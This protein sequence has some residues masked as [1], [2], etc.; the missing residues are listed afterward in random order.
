MKELRV[1][2]IRNRFFA[3]SGLFMFFQFSGTNSVNYYSP[4]IFA[5]LGITG[6]SVSFLATGIYGVVR[7]CAI[8]IAMIWAVD[9]FGRKIL[10]ITFAAVMAASMWIIGA[11]VK[12]QTGGVA[13]PLTLIY[14]YAA[15]FCF[16][17][18]GIPNMQVKVFEFLL[19]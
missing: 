5:R 7:F 1:P 18:A 11:L 10:L 6:Q 16:S 12:T 13:A 3:I 9:R 17:F 8:L 4:T 2:S 14:I 15:A 19:Y